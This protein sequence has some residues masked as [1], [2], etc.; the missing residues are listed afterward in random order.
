MIGGAQ[1]IPLHG[2]GLGPSRRTPNGEE[3]EEELAEA[4]LRGEAWAREALFRS[5]LDMVRGMTIRLA[6]HWRL[7]VDDVVQEVFLCAFE[8]LDTLRTPKYVRS[9]IG[10][11]TVNLVRQQV[12]RSRLRNRFGGGQR[13]TEAFEQVLGQ[14]TP[15][16]VALELREVYRVV[17]ALPE[18]PRT[19]F[20]LRRVEGL[21]LGEVAVHMNASLSSVKR[22]GS[23]PGHSSHKACAW[24]H[25]APKDGGGRTASA[26]Q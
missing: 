6:G 21:S 18:K 24:G 26:R 10:G 9:W 8:R 13:D 12:R 23:R 7:D 20:L 2:N 5:M 14:T 16:D 1:V 3:R 15:P 22:A 25:H 19:V 4:A 11:I 17:E